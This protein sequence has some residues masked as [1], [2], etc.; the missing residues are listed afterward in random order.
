MAHT[1]FSNFVSLYLFTTLCYTLEVI[2][3]VT[4]IFIVYLTTNINVSKLVG[5]SKLLKMGK[6]THIFIYFQMHHV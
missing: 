1:Q 6:F 4:R 5:F 2:G 3:T